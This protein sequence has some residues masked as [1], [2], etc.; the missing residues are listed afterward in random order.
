MYNAYIKPCNNKQDCIISKITIDKLV[1]KL[2]VIDK[3]ETRHNFCTGYIYD[4]KNT[5]NEFMD[6]FLLNRNDIYIHVS[7]KVIK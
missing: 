1:F 3:Y 4:C 7:T 2:I 5:W 6:I